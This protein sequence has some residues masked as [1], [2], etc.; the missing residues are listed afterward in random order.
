MNIILPQHPDFRETLDNIP[1]FWESMQKNSDRMV[2]LLMD[3]ASGILQPATDQ[4]FEDYIFGGEYDEYMGI[5]EDQE[6]ID[7]CLGYQ[8]GFSPHLL[9]NGEQL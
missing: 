4:E 7:Q 5:L 6:I 8:S 2:H 3:S 1:F 9:I